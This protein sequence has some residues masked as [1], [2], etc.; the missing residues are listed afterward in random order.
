MKTLTYLLAASLALFGLTACTP[1]WIDM[2][3]ADVAADD[4]D[5][6]DDSALDDDDSAEPEDTGD[7][8]DSAD[9]GED[10]V[11]P[12]ADD[13]GYSAEPDCDDTD[14]T[15]YPGAPELC[16]GIDNDC[17]EQI[18]EGDVCDDEEFDGYV[19]DVTFTFST[20]PAWRDA[21]YGYCSDL[22]DPWTCHDWN[23]TVSVEQA[24]NVVSFQVS[25]VT[26]GALRANSSAFYGSSECSGATGNGECSGADAWLCGNGES[27]SG[28]VNIIVSGGALVEP[29]D[30]GDGGA[31]CG[32]FQT[33]G[34]SLGIDIDALLDGLY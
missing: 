30:M 4:D 17:D 2:P 5:V 15:V 9:T 28:D 22:S 24:S 8:D 26:G 31:V 29:V 25:G 13:D 16:D 23:Q 6:L 7:D 19:L 11:D 32:P 14:D 3:V 18:D 21:S 34:E 20:A 12:D 1:D 33:G 27:A 10:P